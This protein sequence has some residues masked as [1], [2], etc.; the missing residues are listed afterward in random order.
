MERITSEE[1]KKR[2]QEKKVSK[3]HNRKT[4]IDGHTFHSK[5]EGVRYAE[6]KL[7]EQAGEITRLE[8][9]PSYV[10][11]DSFRTP[12][13]ES[14]RAITY[15]ADFQYFDVKKQRIVVEDVKPSKEFQTDVYKIKKKLFLHKF[16]HLLFEEIY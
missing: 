2:F 15:R 6:L 11:Q 14:I 4:T 1:Y 8:L 13:N 9:Q 16:P 3:Y 12:R 7:L 5:K 10:L